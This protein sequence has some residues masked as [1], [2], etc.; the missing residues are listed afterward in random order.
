LIQRGVPPDSLDIVMASF[1]TQT[2]KQYSSTITSWVSYCTNNNLN[3]LKVDSSHVIS[4][5]T[6]KFNEGASYSS[7]NTHRSA[8][9]IILGTEVT[10]NDCIKRFMKGVYRL[11]PPRPKYN[12]TW[13]TNIVINYLSNKYPYPYDDI[14]IPNLTYKTCTLLCIASAQRMQT[15][16][17]IKLQNMTLQDDA[18][19][20]RN[21]DLI[22]T[23]RPG[24]CQPLIRLPFIRENPNICP[25][26]AL[27]TYIEKTQH[28]RQNS[29][30]GHL[31]LGICKP[32]KEV[33]TQTLARWVKKVLQDSGINISIFGAHST[34]S[35]STSAAHRS[36]VSLEVVRKAAG[37]SNTSNVF[38]KYYYREVIQANQDDFVNAILN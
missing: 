20:I 10:L 22:K 12:L 18:I 25:A 15:I 19:I 31:F 1:S 26:L 29:L 24:A 33:G 16:R 27:Q 5:L 34:R 36:G 7:L 11:N 13:D 37:W 9:S 21:T 17:L 23:S 14:S 4:F 32:H 3:L 6:Q 38:L 28:L 8:L 35:A 30:G 2:L